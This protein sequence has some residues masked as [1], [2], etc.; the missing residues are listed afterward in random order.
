MGEKPED[1]INL[2]Y[3]LG[4][5]IFIL[6]LT[7]SEVK[8]LRSRSLLG[9]H[10]RSYKTELLI[11]TKDNIAMYPNTLCRMYK[12]PETDMRIHL[13]V[14]VTTDMDWITPAQV[15]LNIFIYFEK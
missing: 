7:E 8:K 14:P 4:K 10:Q 5:Y 11:M 6:S 3:E 2:C 1:T 15:D 13:N 9:Q 12:I